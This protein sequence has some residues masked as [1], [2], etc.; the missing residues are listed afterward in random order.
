MTREQIEKIAENCGV[1]V[2]YTEPNKGGVIGLCMTR[3]EMLDEIKA[4]I[5]DLA[6]YVD[7]EMVIE[8]VNLQRVL[9]IID[10]YKERESK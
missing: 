3:T 6:Y 2:S 9:D 5:R 1:E 4:E 8:V 10:K 7:G